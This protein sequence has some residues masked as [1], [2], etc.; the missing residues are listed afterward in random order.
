[1]AQTV[2]MIGLGIMGRARGKHLLKAGY[3]LVAHSSSQGP[4]QEPFNA[5]RVKGRGGLD[6]SGAITLLEE[7]A[8]LPTQS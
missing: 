2:G 8:G 1:M 3:P 6:R 4:V 5:M 7:L